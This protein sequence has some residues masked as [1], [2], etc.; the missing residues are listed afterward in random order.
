VHQL[1][2]LGEAAPR[3]RLALVEEDRPL[4]EPQRAEELAA[5]ARGADAVGQRGHRLER[6]DA[7]DGVER[8]ER[9]RQHAEHARPL[10][11][12][13]GDRLDARVGEARVSHRGAP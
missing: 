11:R 2:R 8:L 4:L 6:A 9:G 5:A 1:V 3:R 13:L 10:E 12:P 7:G